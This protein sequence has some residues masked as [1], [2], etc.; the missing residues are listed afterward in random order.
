MRMTT[1]QEHKTCTCRHVH[2]HV[3]QS[4]PD[5]NDPVACVLGQP[6]RNRLKQTNEN[7][8]V[9]QVHLRCGVTA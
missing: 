6:S 1:E 9:S 8:T 4:V 2:A 3:A 5:P 7:N